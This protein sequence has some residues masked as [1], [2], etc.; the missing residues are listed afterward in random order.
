MNLHSLRWKVEFQ[1]LD[2]GEVLILSYFFKYSK[3]KTTLYTLFYILLFSFSIISWRSFHGKL[4][5][6]FVK[7]LSVPL[8]GFTVVYLTSSLLKDTCFFS[9]TLLL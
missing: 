8:C 1:L 4:P 7:W 6:S 3:K 5:H 2:T 9:S